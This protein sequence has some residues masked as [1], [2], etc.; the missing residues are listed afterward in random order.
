MLRLFTICCYIEKHAH[1]HLVQVLELLIK[2]LDLYVK[3]YELV[4]FNNFKII[5]NNKS[6]IFKE[7]IENTS[8]FDYDSWRNLSF[9]KLFLY[10]QLFEETGQN[11]AWIDMDNLVFCDISYL[12]VLSNFFI[13]NGGKS[14][15]K[16]SFFVNNANFSIE[17][18]NYIQGNFWLINQ[19][20]YNEIIKIIKELKFLQLL[21][22]FDLQDIF[23]YYT[24]YLKMEK[25]IN[26][27]GK[28]RRADCIYGLSVWSQDGNGHPNINGINNMI[29]EDNVLKNKEDNKQIHI[30]S[31]TFDTLKRLL[32]NE[33]F[34]TFLKIV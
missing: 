26:I 16:C 28:N 25:N 21:P 9:N 29:W 3:N 33:N 7:Y 17:R 4:V 18:K 15:N 20:I 30:L 11:Y 13:V 31:F 24:Y 27:L 10:N 14:K 34:K 5:N 2:S 6:V 8:Q 22:K 23:N 32:K 1:R 19:A 12:A